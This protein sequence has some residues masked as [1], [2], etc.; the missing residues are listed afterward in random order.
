M[1]SS[2][3]MDSMPTAR[4]GSTLTILIGMRTPEHM[5]T[6]WM[7]TAGVER[8]TAVDPH[9]LD[10]F[11]EAVRAL[12]AC[13]TIETAS[14]DDRLSYRP[15]GTPTGSWQGYAARWERPD[16]GKEVRPLVLRDGRWRQKGIPRP[17]PLYNLPE[18]LER[19][20]DPVLAVEGE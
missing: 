6:T 16:G 2:Q 11:R 7:E 9:G 14:W 15:T 1:A 10:P 3:M 19:P 17:R 13:T 8:C 20:D 4:G 5:L 18:L 12:Q